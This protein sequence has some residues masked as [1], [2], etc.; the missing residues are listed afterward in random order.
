MVRNGER[1]VRNGERK[2]YGGERCTECLAVKV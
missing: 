1:M 2:G